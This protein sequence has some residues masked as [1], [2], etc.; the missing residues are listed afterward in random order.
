MNS[1]EIAWLRYPIPPK[2]E[3][4]LKRPSWHAEAACRGVS[5]DIFFPDSHEDP[6]NAIAVCT[7]CP[8]RTEC[9]NYALDDPSLKGVWGATSARERSRL[10][11]QAS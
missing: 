3:V 11:Q 2:L 7:S 5:V 4:A 1:T 8:V 9:L 6:R 10:R